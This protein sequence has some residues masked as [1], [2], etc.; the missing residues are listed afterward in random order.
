MITVEQVRKIIQ[1]SMED[2]ETP[3]AILSALRSHDGKRLTKRTIEAIRKETGIDDVV[4]RHRCMDTHIEWGGYSR[5]K[6]DEGGY[7]IVAY[8]EKN[9]V[10][11]VA[12]IEKKNPCY[13]YASRERNEQRNKLLSPE[14]TEKLQDFVDAANEWKEA[15]EKLE[16]MFDYKNSLDV[17]KYRLQNAVG[18]KK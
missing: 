4:L 13:F 17:V 16:P 3:V 5:S 15:V 9:V 12:F 8:S 1:D 10:V 2:A 11:D 18:W 6:G 14:S 7:I